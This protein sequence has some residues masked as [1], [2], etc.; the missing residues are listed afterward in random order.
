[1]PIFMN[2]GQ[3]SFFFDILGGIPVRWQVAAAGGPV[4]HL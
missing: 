4:L 1:M 2:F 3:L